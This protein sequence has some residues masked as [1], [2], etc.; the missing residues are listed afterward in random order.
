ML[1]DVVTYS[2]TTTHIW[3]LTANCKD[4][5]IRSGQAVDPLQAQHTH[6]WVTAESGVHTNSY[7]GNERV[8]GGWVITHHCIFYNKQ[9][10]ICS[11]LYIYIYIYIFWFREKDKNPWSFFKMPFQTNKHFLLYLCTINTSVQPVVDCQGQQG[12]LCWPKHYQNH[13]LMF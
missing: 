6:T 11:P 4:K 9:R 12:L 13:W 3:A 8:M 5:Q 10:T 2:G 7:K 1:S